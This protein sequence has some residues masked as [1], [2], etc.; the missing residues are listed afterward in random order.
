MLL[1]DLRAGDQARDLLL[2]DHLP[3][4][5]LL[6]IGMI[7]IEDHHLGGAA[8]GAAGFDGARGA[9]ADF[10]KAHQAGRLAA[11]GE[12]LAFA[13]QLREIRAGAG[14]VFEQARFAHPQIH[15]AALVDEVVRDRLDEAG[16]RLRMLVG[17]RRLHELAG[18]IVDVEMALARAVDAIGPM[19]A[20]VEP[21]RRI[22]RHHLH[23]QHVAVLVEERLRVGF[24]GEIAALPA[25]IGPGAGQPVEHLLAGLFADE[26]FGLGQRLRAPSRRQRAPQPGRDGLF[27][28]LFQ[29]GRDAGL[30]E[31]FLRQHVGGD[32][33]PLLRNF[34]ILGVENHRTI[35]IADFTRREAESDVRIR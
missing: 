4:D 26:T 28:D 11:A 2:L 13:A 15:D 23:R 12:L 16:M 14:A 33:R 31:I 20:G 34:D 17:G 32:L 8:R 5:E 30:A 1:I 19:Q 6:D 10:Q 35:R 18:P 22:R 9:V 27:L 24:G 3:V 21:L 7:D 25:P 29:A